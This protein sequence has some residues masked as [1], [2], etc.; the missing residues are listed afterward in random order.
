MCIINEI[1]FLLIGIISLWLGIVSHK[2][3][4]ADINR[5]E[6][7]S[8]LNRWGEHYELG[9][10]RQIAIGG[11]IGGLLSVLIFAI[12]IIQKCF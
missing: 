2:R 9:R 11:I 12:R 7:E 3:V 5:L 10:R 4:T 1:S 8:K 6:K